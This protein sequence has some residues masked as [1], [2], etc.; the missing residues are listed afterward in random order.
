V[1]CVTRT[2]ETLDAAVEL[3]FNNWHKGAGTQDMS[4]T[5][6]KAKPAENRTMNIIGTNMP[7]VLT[8]CL[9]CSA[10][11]CRETNNAVPETNQ[12]NAAATADAAGDGAATKPLNSISL[13]ESKVIDVPA[14]VDPSAVIGTDPDPYNTVTNYYTEEGAPIHTPP[15]G[16][17]SYPVTRRTIGPG[18]KVIYQ[19][20]GI[21]IYGRMSCKDFKAVIAALKSM[22]WTEILKDEPWAMAYKGEQ[23]VYNIHVKEPGLLEVET[24]FPRKEKEC[25]HGNSLEFRNE[26]GKWKIRFL[27]NWIF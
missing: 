12:N 23:R 25:P 13:G 1:V 15:P 6:L 19:S 7:L 18:G 16:M 24:L 3:L 2:G 4:T 22:D 9:I 27:S 11:S 8:V 26:N 5:R 14:E 17:V 21:G 20:D 10:L